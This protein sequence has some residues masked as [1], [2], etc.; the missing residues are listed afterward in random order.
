[1]KD[2]NFSQYVLNCEQVAKMLDCTQQTIESKVRA[3]LLPALKYGRSYVFP[4]DALLCE[5]N[6]LAKDNTLKRTAIKIAKE[7]QFATKN[8]PAANDF[9]IATNAG[10]GRLKSTK[11]Y[12]F[13]STRKKKEA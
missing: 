9:T 5:L 1:M 13:G 10:V 6:K 12:D 3:G 4:I 8:T 11:T 2:A 7:R